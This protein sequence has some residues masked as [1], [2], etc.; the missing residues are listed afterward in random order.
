MA[1]YVVDAPTTGAGC[2]AT[3]DNLKGAGRARDFAPE[4]ILKIRHVWSFSFLGG[5]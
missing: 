1:A 2:G 4:W 3:K 5:L